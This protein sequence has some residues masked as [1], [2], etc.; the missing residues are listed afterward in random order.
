MCIY[1]HKCW[2]GF[3]LKSE[4]TLKVDNACPWQQIWGT[5]YLCLATPWQG[6]LFSLERIHPLLSIAK[7]TAHHVGKALLIN[8]K[9]SD[10]QWLMLD[11]NTP[12][13][14]VF[15]LIPT[16][17]FLHSRR[18]VCLCSKTRA[19]IT[20]ASP[21]YVCLDVNHYVVCASVLIHQD[22]KVS[23]VSVG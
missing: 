5:L 6:H 2:Q 11:L 9:D 22:N 1:I 19:I 12:A 3:L 15:F 10:R 7:L 18:D 21:W 8:R 20:Q 4:F 17:S 14:N 16:N 23:Q 13:D